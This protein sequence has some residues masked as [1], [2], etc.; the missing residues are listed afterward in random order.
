[1]RRIANYYLTLAA[2]GKT[3]ALSSHLSICTGE[4]KHLL[5]NQNPV[6]TEYLSFLAPGAHLKYNGQLSR[7][8]AFLEPA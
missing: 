7:H 1:M 8:A 6:F 4:S 5:Y 2:T 3:E